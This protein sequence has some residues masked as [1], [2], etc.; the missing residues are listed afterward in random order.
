MAYCRMDLW[1][2][3]CCLDTLELMNNSMA[4]SSLNVTIYLRFLH[5]DHLCV[6]TYVD[7]KLR[8]SFSFQ[9]YLLSNQKFRL[10]DRL[11]CEHL[12][13]TLS[14][15]SGV[16]PFLYSLSL[17]VWFVLFL[18]MISA[19]FI[20]NSFGGGRLR[21]CVINSESLPVDS[22]TPEQQQKKFLY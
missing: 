3:I 14:S 7:R 11:C 17:F 20:L 21:H 19:L 6:H 16:R 5:Q 1:L 10:P 8:N 13:L 18:Q 12:R 2:R 22:P 9:N 4:L 15:D